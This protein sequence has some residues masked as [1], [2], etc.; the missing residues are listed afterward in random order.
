LP[1]TARLLTTDGSPGGTHDAQIAA[2][3]PAARDPADRGLLA[4]AGCDQSGRISGTSDEHYDSDQR[5][6][7]H[8]DGTPAIAP[9]R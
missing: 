1:G 4:L 8:A 5:Q 9:D 7:V 3:G 2:H 6:W